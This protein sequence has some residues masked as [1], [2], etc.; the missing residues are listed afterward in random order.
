MLR[1]N[2]KLHTTGTM[3]ATFGMAN[4]F[5]RPLGGYMSDA[6]ARHFGMR[7]RLWNL[8]I[9][10]TLG[11]RGSL[12]V[13]SGL[14]GA[15]G[16]L[17]SRST[18]ML[19]FTSSNYS[20]AT[21]IFYMGIMIVACTLPVAAVHFPQWGSMFFPASK[22]CS[23]EKYYGSEWNEEENEKGLHH[24]SLKFVENSISERGR[25][26]GSATTPPAS[27]PTFM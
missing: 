8:Y 4:I 10:Q 3:A 12:G 20:T 16:N 6:A 21:G 24:G 27:T 2:L 14:I 17:G 9:L 11:P 25:R 15:G 7:G 1:F 18:Q 13:I 5:A 26:V 23:E 19:L 22:K